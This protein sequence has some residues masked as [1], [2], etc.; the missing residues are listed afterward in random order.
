MFHRHVAPARPTRSTTG[1]RLWAQAAGE[2]GEPLHSPFVAAA[3][4]TRRLNGPTSK[5]QPRDAG[6]RR[7]T[8]RDTWRAMSAD[9]TISPLC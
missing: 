9:T 8:P 2:D 5:G 7:A 6:H 1:A 4:R 3:H